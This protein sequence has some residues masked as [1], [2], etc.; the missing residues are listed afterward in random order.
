MGDGYNYPLF[1]TST[2]DGRK[3]STPR[4]GRFNPGKEAR[5]PLYRRL[6]VPQSRSGRV[7]K[8]SPSPG[9]DPLTVQVKYGVRVNVTLL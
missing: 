9:F 1:L 2:L 4:P 7:R 3:W 8:I 6:G 5:Y